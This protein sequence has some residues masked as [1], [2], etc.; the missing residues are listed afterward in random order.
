M[1]ADISVARDTEVA[2]LVLNPGDMLAVM[3]P[4]PL[5]AEGRQALREY[6]AASLPPGTPCVILEDGAQLAVVSPPA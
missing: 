2:R 6:L 1:M 4:R 5:S 3:V